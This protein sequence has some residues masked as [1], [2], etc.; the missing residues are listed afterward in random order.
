M[1]P[2]ANIL[3]TEFQEFS[4]VLGELGTELTNSFLYRSKV[5]VLRTSNPKLQPMPWGAISQAGQRRWKQI[6]KTNKKRISLTGGVRP[7]LSLNDNQRK[8]MR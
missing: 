2:P 6:F 1:F 5:H 3:C 4:K 8:T 7:T